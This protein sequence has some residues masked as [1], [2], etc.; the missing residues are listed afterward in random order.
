[1]TIAVDYLTGWSSTNLNSKDVGNWVAG[2]DYVTNRAWLLGGNCGTSDCQNDLYSWDL[3]S[4]STS[5][6]SS[7]ISSSFR[8]FSQSYVTINRTIYIVE[9]GKIYTYNM[10]TNTLNTNFA[11]L[12]DNDLDNSCMATDGRYLF[13]TGGRG[14]IFNIPSYVTNASIFR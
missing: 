10:A 13:I 3:T 5:V 6:T 11:S 2:Y 7:S 12:S 14:T 1:M 9:D 8:T 4:L